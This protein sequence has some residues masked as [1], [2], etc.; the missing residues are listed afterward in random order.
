MPGKNVRPLAGHPL[1][2]YTDRRGARERHL[3]F[4]DRLDRQRETAAIARHYGAEVPFLQAGGNGGGPLTRHRVGEHTRA[5]GCD[6]AGRAPDASASSGRPARSA[7]RD[8][9]RRAWQ[10]FRRRDRS[11][12][13][14][15]SSCAGNTRA[16]CGSSRVSGCGRLLRGDETGVPWHS[17]PYQALPPVHV[18]NASLE[19]AW[20]RTVRDTGTI[21][22]HDDRAVLHPGLRRVRRE[23]SEGT[24][25]TRSISWR[26]AR[27]RCRRSRQWRGRLRGGGGMT[28]RSCATCRSRRSSG[29]GAPPG[30]IPSPRGCVRGDLP[31]QH[32]L[33]DRPGRLGPH[34]QQ[35]QQSRHRVM[36]APGGAAR[37]RRRRSRGLATYTSPRRVT[38]FPACTRC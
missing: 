32:P 3:R 1:L 26:L 31:H 37:T 29:S 27:R 20:T 34:R 28:T 22:G 36:A 11:T 17:R 33:H 13:S 35:L 6:A 12:R 24:G 10:R 15:R 8:T 5:A 4:G 38:T 18:Q 9:I 23:R 21:A 2:A 25:G 7:A 30:P 14:V 16:R 19:I